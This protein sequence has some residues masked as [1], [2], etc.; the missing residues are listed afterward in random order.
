M[1]IVL[2]NSLVDYH[3]SCQWTS[4]LLEKS[5]QFLTPK[6]AA[7]SLAITNEFDR[8]ELQYFISLRHD[9]SNKIYGTEHIPGRM[10]KP[11]H[12][13]VSIPI[14]VQKILCKWYATLYN[15]E[16]K[17][18]KACME[19]NMNQHARLQIGNEIF[20]SK[21]AGRHE[22]N[23][24]ILAKWNAYRDGTSDIYPGEVQYY[25]EHTLTLPRGP[26]THLL[27]YVKWYKNASSSSIRF[28]HKF[29]E[30]EVSNTELWNEEYYEEGQ[31]SIIAVHRIYGRVIKIDYRVGNKKNEHN[32]VSIIPLNRRFNV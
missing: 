13:K 18:V 32:Y 15:R 29:M 10:L 5:L 30:P 20:G 25:F 24:I 7:G 12:K 21:I 14:E 17:D 3:L 16:K 27:A 22:N 23:A 19:V 31:D 6:K 2:K 11:S 4:G 9:M 8:E 26:R 28:K 1:K